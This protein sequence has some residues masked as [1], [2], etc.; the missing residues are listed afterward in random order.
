MSD[1]QQ[2]PLPRPGD[3]TRRRWVIWGTLFYC[4]FEVAFITARPGD[5]LAAPTRAAIS[6]ALILLAGGVIGSYVF[7]A[8]WDDQNRRRHDGDAT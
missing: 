7:G 3:W 5:A 2:K 6:Q 1:T 8:T 4:A